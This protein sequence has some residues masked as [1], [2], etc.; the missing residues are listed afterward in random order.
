MSGA[1]DPLCRGSFPVDEAAW[2]HALLA[3]VRGLTA[4]RHAH[5][6]LRRGTF[7]QAGA[8]GMA[9]AYLRS[10]DGESFL[11]AFDAGE[12][13]ALLEVVVG[14]GHAG[15]LT[16]VVPPGWAWPAG[17]EVP[18]IGGRATI[19]LPARGARILRAG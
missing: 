14:G 9:A 13:P 10:H 19:A 11:I 2:D 5:P 1:Q 17:D 6:A 12:E 7:T 15:T 8:Q 4:L 3:Y 16:P 18:V